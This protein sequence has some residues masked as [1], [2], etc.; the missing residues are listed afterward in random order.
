[1]KNTKKL[2][3]L[4][5]T[6]VMLFVLCACDKGKDGTLPEEV[7]EGEWTAT[8]DVNAV[9]AVTGNDTFSDMASIGLTLEKCQLTFV[10]EDGKATMKTAEMLDWC[11]NYLYAVIDFVQDDDNAMKL[12]ALLSNCTVEELEADMANQGVTIADLRADFDNM[13]VGAALEELVAEMGDKTST[14]QLDGNRLIFEENTWTYTYS[15]GKITVTRIESNVGSTKLDKD[16]FVLK[17]K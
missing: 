12:F 6:T 10:F 15:N 13:D 8:L 7:L 14:Y 5:L 3:A 4:L 11:E 2:L 17:K 1:M 16:D 9:G